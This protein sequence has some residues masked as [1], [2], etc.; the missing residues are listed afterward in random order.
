MI[1]PRLRALI[2]S[3]SIVCSTAF[4]AEQWGK[5]GG[6]LRIHERAVHLESLPMGP[7][8]KLPDGGLVT[9]DESVNALV[10]RD[11]GRTWH[12]NRIFAE[13]DKFEIRPERAILGTREG[14]V[15]VAFANNAERGK[16]RWDVKTH[17]TRGK[18]HLPTYVVRSVDGG[19]TWERPQKMHDDWT[20]AIRDMI[21]T[22]EGTIV[23]TSMMLRHK[24][25][26]HTVVTYASRDDGRTWQ[27]SNVIDLGGIGHHG[28]ATEATIV[29]L[30]DGSLLMLMRSNWGKLWRCVSK[31][32][33]LTWH[34]MGPGT[35]DASAA[36]AILERLQ[37]GRIFLAW[38]RYYYEG[39]KDFPPYGGDDHAT[40]TPTSVQRRELSIAFSEDEGRTWGEPIVVARAPKSNG[41]WLNRQ[42]AYPY[43]FERRPG[44]IWLTSW[45]GGLRVKL[46]EEVFTGP[47]GRPHV[48]AFG[49]TSTAR[50]GNLA[51]YPKQIREIMRERGRSIH[52]S[53]A[54]EP[55]QNTASARKV[56]QDRVLRRQPRVVILQFGINDA[57]IDVW[58]DPPAKG[59]RV[60]IGKYEEN[61]R[62]FIAKIRAIGA[63]PILMTPNPLAWTDNLKKFYGKPPY[64]LEDP[65]GINEFL[66]IYAVVCRKIAADED[67][68]LVDVYRAFKSRT[69]KLLLDGMHPNQAGHRLIAELLAP[70]LLEAV[71]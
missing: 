35:I 45:P 50:R 18:P 71:D 46:S 19:K 47:L 41:V 40:G 26:R 70:V 61:L 7:F 32:D 54:A 30:A 33:G 6:E 8:A 24:P 10:S 27:Q 43:V 22:R 34:P 42:V 60:P 65:N 39:T 38:N 31:D 12:T 2:S 29:Q 4:A 58:K 59:S 25:G 69:D 13:P 28:G 21:Q 44:E 14:M 36:P 56:L 16:F 5:P 20:G 23:F 64:K 63:R 48:I 62:H 1:S 17:D 67:V 52:V 55:M 51:I 53:N 9:V 15:I 11:D 57:A 37:S 66:N 49:D 3:V 68:P